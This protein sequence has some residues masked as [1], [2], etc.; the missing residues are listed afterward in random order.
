MDDPLLWYEG[1]STAAS[2]RRFL[3]ADERGSIIG[4]SDNAGTVLERNTYDDWGI[5]SPGNIG[6][7][8]Y[9]GQMRLNAI[10]LNYY[11]ARMYSPSL[12]RFMQTDPIGYDDG[13]NMY[14][15]VGNDP[16]N[17]TDPTGA[18]ECTAN[19]D[20]CNAVASSV[21]RIRRIGNSMRHEGSRIRTRV[22][23]QLVATADHLGSAGDGN[24]VTIGNF[25]LDNGA[26]EDASSATG[27]ATSA[28]N[29]NVDFGQI[30]GP[31]ADMLSSHNSH[32]SRGQVEEYNL[33]ATLVHEGTHARQFAAGLSFGSAPDVTRRELTAY[34][35]E[36]VVVRQLGFT[37]GLWRP[38]MTGQAINRGIRR[39]ALNS[40]AM[41]Q[42]IRGRNPLPGNCRWQ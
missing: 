26:G 34:Y 16:L 31:S 38:G 8:G 28:T 20:Q 41:T 36:S 42:A 35:Y 14:A 17:A 2:N 13:M 6:R 24:G 30:S 18:Y 25:D 32:L 22:G 11:K 27:S 40:C 9:T 19:R 37:T 33:T 15:Y 39:G 10:G 3:H 7:F 21:R 1:S 29:I 23:N 4:I 12:G 5:P